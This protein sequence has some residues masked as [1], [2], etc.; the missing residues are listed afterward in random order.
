MT[1]ASDSIELTI[2]AKAE[3][4]GVVRLALSGITNR[5]GF[6]YDDIEDIKVAVSEA[7][8][9]AVRHAYKDDV[10]GRVLIRVTPFPDR[11]EIMVID[12]GRSFDI[13]RISGNLKPLSAAA[14]IEQLNEGGLGLFLIDTLMD[15]VTI[16]GE[17]GVVVFMTKFLGGDEVANHAGKAYSTNE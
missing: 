10:E 1:T 6:S 17:S 5:M 12:S 7:I 2:P 13:E 15:R 3:Y 16:S 8:T 9:N 4:I 11:I 14:S